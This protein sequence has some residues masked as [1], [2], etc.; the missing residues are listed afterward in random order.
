MVVPSSDTSAS[1]GAA[2]LAGL[3][4]GMYDSAEAAMEKI[5][6]IRRSQAPN[7][8]NGPLY[9]QYYSLYRQL[10]DSGRNVMAHLSDLERSRSE[11]NN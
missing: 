4:V 9:H 5:V 8:E 3:G 1:C 2:V 10:Y 11:R 6:K 7:A